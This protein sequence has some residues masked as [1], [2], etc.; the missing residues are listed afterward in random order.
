[1]GA[2]EATRERLL[3]AAAEVFA[4]LGFRAATVRQIV[5][6]A[7][8]NVAAV[9]YHFR[10]KAGLY[11]EVLERL[12]ADAHLR[13]PVAGGARPDAP[14][15]ERLRAF[16]A[17]FLHRITDPGLQS[18]VGRLMAREMIEPTAALDRIVERGIRPVYAHLVRLV[19][20]IGRG[21]SPAAAERAAKSVLGQILFYKHCAPVI[22]RIDGRL[23]RRPREIDALAA[24]ITRFSLEGLRR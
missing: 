3:E 20:G 2:N 5:A 6:R 23:P 15:A 14:A 10:D 17:A 11:A 18:R 13:H 22:E 19:R 1:M 24:H 8:A 12:F 9:N 4:D 21:M 16:V 7:K